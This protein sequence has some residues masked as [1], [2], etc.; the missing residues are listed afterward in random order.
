MD[1]KLKK[2][3]TERLVLRK[4]KKSDLN[5]YVEWRANPEYHKFL[6][7]RAKKNIEEYQDVIESAVESY[8][9]PNTLPYWAVELK[10]IK[11]M[12]GFV[13]VEECLKKHKSITM[14]WGLNL[15]FQGYGYA[16]EAV[17]AVI[18]YLFNE[19]DIHRIEVSIWEGNERSRK[20]AEKLGFIYEG[21]G[22]EARLKEGRFI[23]NWRFSL[24]K[25]EWKN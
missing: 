7:S 22:R 19:Y 2:I 4:L 12:I 17:R 3:E 15:D 24:L 9:D 21:M 13:S 10:N 25:P 20:L 8:S 14:G 16:Y 1:I 23:N 18:N 5:D 11:K 6:S